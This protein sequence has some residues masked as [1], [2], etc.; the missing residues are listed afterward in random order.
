MGSIPG[1][2]RS[3][4]G[5][6]GNRFQYSCL[7]NPVDR[8][9]WWATIHGVTRSR[10]RLKCLSTQSGCWLAVSHKL[11]LATRKQQ[12]ECF[13]V[14]SS[15]EE[16]EAGGCDGLGSSKESGPVV[17]SPRGWPFTSSA[18][19]SHRSPHAGFRSI[20][21]HC[22]PESQAPASL[23]PLFVTPKASGG[24]LVAHLCLC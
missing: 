11:W 19:S 12:C 6:P 10:T 4:G 8:G 15:L 2:G 7:E 13:R 3:P 24:Q 5:G 17:V 1:S 22:C 18:L 21:P 14:T 20:S 16:T 23:C 9:A